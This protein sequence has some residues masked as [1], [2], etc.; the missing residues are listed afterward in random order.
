MVLRIKMSSQDNTTDLLTQVL[1]ILESNDNNLEN[2]VNQLNTLLNL[3][4]EKV[5]RS[6]MSPKLKELLGGD[7]IIY[8]NE[9]DEL[10][11]INDEQRIDEI[12]NEFKL[13]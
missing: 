8:R 10:K 1:E 12:K 3:Y 9:G 4:K 6:N 11:V 2:M 5:S 13:I 7:P